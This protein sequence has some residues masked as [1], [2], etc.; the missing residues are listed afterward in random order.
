MLALV[1]L[2]CRTVPSEP[3]KPADASASVPLSSGNGGADGGE[4]PEDPSSCAVRT[5]VAQATA[6]DLAETITKLVGREP[7]KGAG[8]LPARMPCARPDDNLRTELATKLQE[9]ARS[10]NSNSASV[11]VMG[12]VRYACDD[13]DTSMYFDGHYTIEGESILVASF[14]GRVPPGAPA[15]RRPEV[16]ARGVTKSK[17]KTMAEVEYAATG[18]FDGDGKRDAVYMQTTVRSDR[19]QPNKAPM[20]VLSDAEK[21]ITV[22]TAKG[23][24]FA[25]DEVFGMGDQITAL[26]RDGAPAVIVRTRQEVYAGKE[27]GVR[28]I[29]LKNGKLVVDPDLTKE[30]TDKLAPISKKL[31]DVLTF[32]C[33]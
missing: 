11:P 4:V 24:K 22:V 26:T 20:N 21:R 18:D 13:P 23:Q 27:A 15:S 16:I 12:L 1:S 25:F 7:P 8:D 30:L 19:K 33:M 28:I 3:T 32:R 10:E 9:I 14:L 29:V 5:R 6:R 31:F 17:D 2:Q